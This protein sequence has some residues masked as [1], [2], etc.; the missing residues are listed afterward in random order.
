MAPLI[1]RFGKDPFYECITCV[2]AQHREMLDQVVDFFNIRTD[3]DLNLMTEGQQPAQLLG[4]VIS[5]VGEELRVHKPD[6]VFVQGDTSTALGAT[7]AA[8][9]AG[10][11]TAHVEAGLRSHNI[12]VPFPE[13]MNR[14]CIAR[15]AT[16]HFCPVESAK[17][18]LYNE[19]IHTHVVVTGNTVIDALQEAERL[20]SVQDDQPEKR[21]VLITCHRRESFGEPLLRIM[22]AIVV[23]ADRFPD[24]DFIF[25]V[26]ANPNVGAVARRE[27][28]RPNILLREPFRYDEQ[29]RQ[30]KSCTLILTDSGGIQEEAPSLGKLC[31]VLRDVTERQE[32]VD[33]GT[34]VLVGT[35]TERIVAKVTEVLND[36][37][38]QQRISS[39]ANPF[40]DGTASERIHEYV[41]KYF[42]EYR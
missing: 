38:A 39:L 5:A 36:A 23:L 33:A 32:A 19:G 11:K 34:S 13:E 25:P 42:S 16:F 28:I 2:T 9:Y 24:V 14:S 22:K 29:V 37:D 10:I 12:L 17:Q 1:S 26:H 35:D 40:G 21:K 6:L 15:M 7:Y 30:M 27:L 20:V 8:F 3:I 4:K 41:T 18:N 31:I